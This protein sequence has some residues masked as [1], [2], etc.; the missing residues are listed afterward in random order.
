MYFSKQSAG[1][2]LVAGVMVGSTA[3]ASAT[4]IIQQSNVLSLLAS[5]VEE[6]VAP[7]STEPTLAP[8]PIPEAAAESMLT[9]GFGGGGMAAVSS[10]VEPWK[11]VIASDGFLSGRITAIAD[12]YNRAILASQGL[13]TARR[14]QRVV[15]ST[16][17]GSGGVFQMGKLSH[18]RYGFVLDGR[19][20]VAIFGQ[21][22]VDH[23]AGET[24]HEIGL[25]TLL[26][27]NED[28]ALIQQ[29]QSS[30]PQGSYWEGGMI[31]PPEEVGEAVSRGASFLR[32]ADGVVEGRIVIPHER[33]IRAADEMDIV[34]ARNGQSVGTGRSNA[35]GVFTMSGLTPGYYSMIAS[36]KHGFLAIGVHVADAPLDPVVALGGEASEMVATTVVTAYVTPVPPVDLQGQI[37]STDGNTNPLAGQFGGAMG[38]PGG[39][40]GGGGGV[41]GGMGGGLG[42]LGAGLGAAALGLAL[43]DD[44]IISPPGP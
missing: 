22:V 3:I 7:P 24:G 4:A 36:G 6:T 29:I 10:S 12:N 9:Q 1:A 13:V 25:E 30:T 27:A 5:Q 21:Y 14:D 31:I 38:G 18:G 19:E 32:R 20:G 15:N 17:L 39:G 43:D 28:R 23:V 26:C 2:F 37:I 40:F 42:L 34:F 16:K 44:D 11:A 33:D 35:E 41:G 8:L